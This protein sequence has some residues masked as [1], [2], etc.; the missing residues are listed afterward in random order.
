MPIKELR[1]TPVLM[2]H[3]ISDYTGPHFRT[4]T[5]SPAQLADQMRYLHQNGYTPLTTTDFA[6]AV[7]SQKPLPT[8][9]VV[10]TFDDGFADFKTQALP[11]LKHYGFAG[12]V[13]IPTKYVGDTSRWMDS[14]GE[15]SRPLLTWQDIR[16]ISSSKIELG[17]HSH[18]HPEMDILSL[19]A[20]REEIIQS[21]LLLEDHLKRPI[22]SFCYP[23][24]YSNAAVRRL[25]REAGF[26]SACAGLVPLDDLFAIP[27]RIVTPD[28]TTDDFGKL[29]TGSASLI[30][31][32]LR[33]PAA[34]VWRMIRKIRSRSNPHI[35]R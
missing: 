8:R 6:S 13:Y 26:T 11:V 31:R 14:I 28:M 35:I 32:T 16:E 22:T 21:K 24:T 5:I 20:A 34:V 23:H 2:Y 3:S 29:L 9:P 27:R 17:A 25:V 19:V 10:L 12:T 33:P 18:T 1:T 4:F 30:E 15:G 7:A